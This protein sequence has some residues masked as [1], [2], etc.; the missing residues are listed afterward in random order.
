MAI[1]AS[2]THTWLNVANTEEKQ[3]E[4]RLDGRSAIVTG[5]SKGLG[6]AM[7][8]EFAASGADVAMLARRPEVLEEAKQIVAST[9]Q[10]GRV[11]T[12]VC[13]VAKADDIQKTFDGVSK[14]F[15][16]VDILINNAGLGEKLR[17]E[18]MP[19]SVWNNTLTTN[20]TGSFLLSQ[21]VGRGMIA[22]R[23]GKIVN[24]ASR[25]AFMGM[26]F[27]AAYNASKAGI[28]ALTRTL[29]VEWALYDIQVNAIVPGVVRTP[30]NAHRDADPVEEQIFARTIPLG[31]ISEPED[32]LGATLFLSSPASAYVTGSVVFVDG[33]NYM[34]DGIGTEYRDHRLSRT[35][36]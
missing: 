31:R 10:G 14:T 1:C 25:C 34:A 21:A 12:F 35:G 28:V 36:A 29:A 16:K 18:E 22:R 6:L 11:A 20:L 4:V 13:D 17:A 27:S 8:K 19:L 7:A 26:P 15:G 3:M 30:M 2:A 32:L 24:I 5:A 9:A 33:G 23:S